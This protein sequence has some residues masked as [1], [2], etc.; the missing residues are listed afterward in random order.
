MTQT[1]KN[2]LIN[3]I[4]VFLSS[5]NEEKENYIRVVEKN[6]NDHKNALELIGSGFAKDTVEAGELFL[7]IY[8]N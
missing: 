6:L 3:S 4:N 2:I 5:T 8:K 7:R 1:T